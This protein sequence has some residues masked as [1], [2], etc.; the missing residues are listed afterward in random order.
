MTMMG[1]QA[2]FK[3]GVALAALIVVVPEAQAQVENGVQLVAD[4]ASAGGDSEISGDI[5][6][7]ARRRDERLQDVPAAISAVSGDTLQT[8]HLDRIA[9]FAAKLPN[10]SA[11]QQ[12]TRVSGLY[13]RGLGGNANNDGAE[14]G[15]GLIVDNVFLTHV[16][17]S[18]LDFVDLDHIELVRGPQGTL[19]GKNTTI[20][21]L[22]VT[23]KRPSFT[24]EFNLEAGYA[25]F[26]R[27]QI[28]ANATGPVIGDTLAYRLT[29][30]QDKSNGWARNRVDGQKYL[31]VNR[32]AVRGQLLFDSGPV[33]SRL[34]AEHYETSEYNNYYPNYADATNFVNGTP[35][36]GSWDT[37]MRTIFGYTP[38]YE[39]GKNADLNTQD[40]IDSRVNGISNELNIKL[41]SH[42]LTAV[43]AWR[44]LRFRPRN[45][46]DQSPFSI[47][48]AGF[49]VDV[50][51]Y[52]QEVRLASPT[53]GAVDYQVGGY[54]LREDLVSNNRSIFQSDSTKWFLTGSLPPAFLLPAILNGV[55]YDQYGKL[56]VTSGAAFGQATWHITDRAALTGGVRFTRETKRASNT[57]SV[58]GGAPLPA[59]LEPARTGIIAAFGGIFSVADSRTTDSWSWLINPSYKISDD[60]LLYASVSYGEKSGAANLSATKNKPVIIDP[61]KS[62]DYEIGVKA[63][64]AGGR[65]TLSTN[66]YWTDIR[67]YQAVQIDPAKVGLGNFLGNAAAVRLRGVEV[68]GEAKLGAGFSASFSG[69]YNDATYRS[70]RNAPVPIEFA[71]PNGPANLD[72]SGKRVIGSAKWSGQASIA[73]DAPIS[74][75]IGLNGYINQTYRSATNLL[76]PYS[77]YGNQAGYGLTNAGIGLHSSDD[78]YS[79]LFWGRNLFDKRYA[80]GLGA[81]GAVNPFIKV[82]GDPRT[83]GATLKG[84]F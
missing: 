48:R 53:G 51:Q 29:F 25:N 76:N 13:V 41:G 49:D 65:A 52:S 84:R 62:T 38:N 83:F 20:G 17:F 67:D 21:A 5:L 44:Q 69:S 8:Q 47:L 34:I 35:R 22:I 37:K 79:L 66:F 64:L 14:A 42:T 50:D 2:W 61:E 19:L 4:D 39:V 12:N 3:S 58:F 18:W 24:P 31:D 68:E 6:V 45:D 72:L 7:T 36:T 46:S 77:A 74:D 9:D 23:T 59:L 1:T 82:L 28:R 16:G 43:T 81:A 32:W 30:Y 40:R 27:Y 63:T 73:Y 55:E 15:V 10:F 56:K 54:F 57:G 71:Y 75:R 33:T 80:V 60:V 11:V 78:R 26:G 70:Y